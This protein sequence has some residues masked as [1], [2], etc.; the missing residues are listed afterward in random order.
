MITAGEGRCKVWLRREDMGK[1]IIY[2]V[3]G[4]ERP[5]IGGAVLM[6]TG[7]ERPEAIQLG[8][9]RDHEILEPIALEA[10]KK[11]HTTVIAVGGIHID[12][13]TQEEI[14]KIVENCKELL[15]CI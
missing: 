9:H 4:G 12:N 10:H 5:H 3:G 8:T 14:T 6:S 7:M 15:K 1:D 2:L 11:Y 13:A